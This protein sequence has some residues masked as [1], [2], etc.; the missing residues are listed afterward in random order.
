ME[1]EHIPLLKCSAM[2][3]AIRKDAVQTSLKGLV[4]SY[5]EE[6]RTYLTMTC[7]LPNCGQEYTIYYGPPLDKAEIRSGFEAY[8]K[9]DHPNHPVIYEIDESIPNDPN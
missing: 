5:T 3:I 7:P 4:E 1:R 2:A 9:R 6:G 8:L